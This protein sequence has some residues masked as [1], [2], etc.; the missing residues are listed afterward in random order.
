LI[1]V[2]PERATIED[3][4]RIVASLSELWGDLR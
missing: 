3:L 4:Q 2:I 1:P